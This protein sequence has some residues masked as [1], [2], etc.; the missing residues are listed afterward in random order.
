MALLSPDAAP[1]AQADGSRPG[2]GLGPPIEAPDPLEKYRWP[3]L[4][5]FALLLIAGAIFMAKR[6]RAAR[7]S[8]LE[9]SAADS[10][11]ISRPS[12]AASSSRSP[13]LLEALKEELFALEMEHKQRRIS[14]EEYEAAKA[15]LDRTLER[16]LKRGA[17]S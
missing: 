12:T 3:L 4:G 11:E 5:G 8:D 17:T 16:A 1:S 10:P 13:L 9:T 14:Q 7:I 2:G 15:A 6:P